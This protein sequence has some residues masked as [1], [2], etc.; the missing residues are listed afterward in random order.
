MYAESRK[1]LQMNLVPQQT[2]RMGVWTQRGKEREGQIGRVALTYIHGRVCSGELLGSCCIAQ[3][4]G[5]VLCDNVEGWGV[6]LGGRLKKEEIC[7]Y[8]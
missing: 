4:D 6:V 7:V 3:G 2:Q 1:M 5:L 8:M